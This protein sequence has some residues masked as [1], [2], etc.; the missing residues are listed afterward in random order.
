MK[1]V[2][3]TQEDPFYLPESI[4]EFINKVRASKK[5]EI[6]EAIIS[7][8]SPFGKK[9]GFRQKVKKTYNVFGFRFFLYYSIKYIYRK[10][11]LGKSVTKTVVKKKLSIWRLNDS[12]NSKTNVEKLKKLKPDI[13]IIIAGNQ[14]IKRQILEIPKYGAI[15]AHSSLLPYYKGLM[16]TFWVLKNNEKETGVTV[17]KLTEGIDDGPIIN[18]KKINIKPAMTQADLVI[19]C[20]NI[21]NELI[22]EALDLLIHPEKF[23]ENKGGSYYKFP[24]RKDVAEF[25]NS[26]KKFY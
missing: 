10:F 15:N 1:I 24:T 25:Y 20:K 17:Y 3:L 11:I 16:P 13:L 2:L 9:E 19:K 18:Q 26:G 7:S 8:A 23:I 21:A 5:H 22:I 6:L 4:E 14:I 12:I